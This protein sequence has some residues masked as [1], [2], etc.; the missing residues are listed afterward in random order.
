MQNSSKMIQTSHVLLV[1]L[2]CAVYF[3]FCAASSG[4]CSSLGFL[5]VFNTTCSSSQ[6]YCDIDRLCKSRDGRCTSSPSCV[7]I[8][9]IETAGCNCDASGLRCLV[10]KGSHRLSSKKRE[11]RLEHDFIEYKGFVWEYGCYGTRILDMNDPL[12]VSQ[13][14]TPLRKN[15]IGKSSCSYSQALSFLEHTG[16]RYTS[17][18]YSLV[19]NNCQ[20][21]A[22]AFS[23]WLLDD[24]TIRRKRD[25]R[26]TPT[27]LTDYFT[28]LIETCPSNGK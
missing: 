6:Y 18:D 12:F 27:D 9:G 1:W 10:T 8:N 13:R 28:Q 21:F 17:A 23:R 2:I 19:F 11:I 26:D 3:E 24:C 22:A 15:T 14:P 20:D 4:S 25:T 7:Y 16:N 5:G